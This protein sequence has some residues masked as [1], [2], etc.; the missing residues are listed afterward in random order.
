MLSF[1][2]HGILGSKARAN[3][4]YCISCP[5]FC[6]HL[7]TC[8]HKR[9]SWPAVSFWKQWQA[10]EWALGLTGQ[11]QIRIYTQ[12]LTKYLMSGNPRKSYLGLPEYGSFCLLLMRP[13]YIKL[14]LSV[15]GGWGWLKSEFPSVCS[16]QFMCLFRG[17]LIHRYLVSTF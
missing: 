4:T 17:A 11:S 15:S 7:H 14:S 8:A 16:H 6:H 10:S 13:W 12:V 1:Q 5:I 2:F 9:A 3:S